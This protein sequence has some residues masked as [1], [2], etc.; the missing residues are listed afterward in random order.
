[1]A[2]LFEGNYRPSISSSHLISYAPSGN[3]RELPCFENGKEVHELGSRDLV[4]GES[5]V[6][7]NHEVYA[8][9]LVKFIE[10]HTKVVLHEEGALF[11]QGGPKLSI[12]SDE[13]DLVASKNL[14]A[15]KT[16]GVGAGRGVE[17]VDGG[18]DFAVFDLVVV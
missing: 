13:E 6:S 10:D 14:K 16:E 17:V 3:G 7:R 11:Y 8:E 5:K 15:V 9:F 2:N 1:M 18:V 12:S 4:E